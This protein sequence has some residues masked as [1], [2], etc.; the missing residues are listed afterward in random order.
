MIF[1]LIDEKIDA[2][3]YL[4]GKYIYPR[5]LYRIYYILAKWFNSQGLS[6][7]EIRDSIF[8][9][10][11]KY[12]I[13]VKHCLNDIIDSVI[14]SGIPLKQD[15]VV[16]INQSDIHEINRHFDKKNTK[17]VALAI[18][19][20]AKIY[21]DKNKE[22]NLSSVPFGCW[23]GISDSQIRARYFKEL[24]DYSYMEKVS[25][26]KNN[27]KWKN[28]DDDKTCK[29]KLLVDIDNSG[30]I[31]LEGNHINKLSSSIFQNYLL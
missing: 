6:K 11:G 1:K 7:I 8:E 4:S 23:I 27:Y 2:L 24:I 26:P 17:L 29:Y 18:L 14:D 9:W 22:F 20:Y 21:A 28:R 19:C 3:N 31:V 16:R 10:A 13:T 12:G 30:D 5:N 25:T 15:V